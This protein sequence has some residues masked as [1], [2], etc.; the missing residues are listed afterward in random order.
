MDRAAP[1][2]EAGVKERSP[3]A[4]VLGPPLRR[5]RAALALAALATLVAGAAEVLRPWPLKLALDLF[6]AKPDRVHA[7][8]GPF[9]FLAQ[10]PD[11]QALA[12]L[13]L[14]LVAV[15]ALAGAFSY[16]QAIVLAGVGQRAILE[17]RRRLFL[18][19]E[20][21]SL[22]F[23][24]RHRSG[25]LLVHL[26]GDLNVLSDFLVTQTPVILG[27]GALLVGM[28][29]IMLWMDPWLTLA[30]LAF[31]PLL[32]WTVRRHVSAL[33]K[34]A[35]EQRRREGKI[36][37]VAGESLQL[38]QVVQAFGA[39]QQE[40]ERLDFE[41]RALLGA[42]LR[43]GRAEALLQ[44]GV[45]L[46][47]AAGTGLV[48]YLGVQH[49]RSGLLSAGDLV[50]FLS[51]LRGVQKPMRDLA[52]SVQRYAKASACARRV[53]QL[54]DTEPEVVDRP[55]SG[56]APRLSGAI[57]FDAVGFSYGVGRPALDGVTFRLEPGE[58]V[59][60]VG[61]TGAGKTTLLALLGRFYDP[62]SG[63][64]R[65]D[66]RDLRDWT[67]A[68]VRSQ[69]A[70]V[71]QEAALFGTTIRENLLLGRPD[72]SE[73]ELWAALADAQADG[74]VERLPAGL[75]TPLGERGS[76][77][78]GGQ[79][80]RLA[81]ARAMLRDAPLLLLDEPSTGLDA[82]TDRAV[83]EALERLARGRTTIV[84]A[85]QLDTVCHADRILVLER[86]RL[87]G[88]GRHAELLVTCAAYRRLWESR[89]FLTPPAPAAPF[90]A[91]ETLL[92]QAGQ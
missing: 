92:R 9:A 65:I 52:Q 29:A 23:H 20:R 34:A 13:A 89:A 59:A 70:L 63:V 71:L 30:S 39:E 84:I 44:R 37:G 19:L 88:N 73:E 60:V 50:V 35:R 91:S 76:T 46:V 53:S 61:E 64:I 27:R 45:E 54:L 67:L 55:G 90:P 26:V 14:G 86:G 22:A 77:L 12:A 21:L 24:R 79:R 80:Q 66:G 28:L 48:L 81:V 75:D 4:K 7:K 1:G 58:R 11:S 2:W 57:A 32:A 43:A 62:T 74:F 68:S 49:A 33:R 15:A 17:L 87:V 10:W 47:G 40:A 25:E 51:Y 56:P 83:R 31:F 72:A 3:L 78:S 38:I 82:V 18:H 8:L 16:V 85:H 5:N 41:G 69:I 6:L 36:A 42:G